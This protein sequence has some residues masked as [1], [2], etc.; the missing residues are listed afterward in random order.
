MAAEEPEPSFS[1]VLFIGAGF[2]AG[3]QYPVGRTLMLH[4]VNYLN[5][6][7][8]QEELEIL[9]FKNLISTKMDYCNKADQ[10][11]KVIEQ[12]LRKY[13]A[14]DKVDQVDVSEFFTIAHTLAQTPK[15][16]N[17][18][19]LESNTAILEK[20]GEI[21][22]E[23]TLFDDLSAATRTYFTAIGELEHHRRDIRSILTNL[24]PDRD[25]IVNFNWDEEIEIALDPRGTTYTF[26]N[27]LVD[28]GFLV[29][30]PHG[31]ISWYDV[32]Q[33]IGNGN[34]YFITG[35]DKRIPRSKRRI[36]SYWDN[37]MPKDID[38]RTHPPLSCP[39]VITPP[40]FAK[41]FE[42]PEQQ[43]IWQD[44]LKVC[45]R[46]RDFI[47][48]GYSLPRDDFL[49][50][51]AIRSSLQDNPDLNLGEL[52]CLVVD[53]SFDVT[54]RI[55]FQSV[56]KG[57]TEKKNFLEWEFGSG[58]PSLVDKLEEKLKTARLSR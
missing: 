12:V 11:V 32:K 4:L 27:W 58:D 52:R 10:I 23:T 28:R 47:F 35:Q 49:T 36:M 8:V 25:A 17:I 39:P 43:Y 50:R 1:R 46:A 44:V 6:K 9:G 19:E 2:S 55:N 5:R 40:T 24:K 13:F 54:K 21:P 37:V 31:S 20:S 29:L 7:P 41:R 56:F 14:T 16:F 26:G 57:L 53:R 33:G 18:T 42:Y 45:S 30:K 34:S 48:L 38:K 51:A 22:S 3:M 15:L